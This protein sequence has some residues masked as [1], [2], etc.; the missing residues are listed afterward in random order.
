[1]YSEDKP[2]VIRDIPWVIWLFALLMFGTGVGLFNA[3]E[4]PK[5]FM[6]VIILIG[7]ALLAFS[8][9]LTIRVDRMSGML[10]IAHTGLLRHSRREIPIGQ[11]KAVYV[12]QSI[13]SDSDGTSYTYQVNFSLEDGEVIPLRKYTSSGYRAKV[14]RA[15]QLRQALGVGGHDQIPGQSWTQA[16]VELRELPKLAGLPEG[17]QET[18]GVRWEWQAH[19][20]G[21]SPITRWFSA[22]FETPGYFLFLA[23]KIPGQDPQ[24]GLMGLIGNTL[25]KQSLKMYGFDASYTPGLESAAVLENVDRRLEEFFFIFTSSPAEARQILN[26]WAVSPLVGWADRHALNRSAEGF[27][28]MT[29]LFSPWGV[30]LS[31]LNAPMPVF[32]DELVSLGVEMILAQGKPKRE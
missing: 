30:Y 28:Q 7:L 23:Q 11:V 15:E 22:D 8:P 4:S 27:T 32:A 13:S 31:V 20:L 6:V 18:N 5:F 17:E 26:P 9:V 14:R 19:S 1:M 3:P 10:V 24:K 21:P 12:N 29:A 25:F 16:A 2:L